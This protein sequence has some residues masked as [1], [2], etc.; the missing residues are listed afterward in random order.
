MS[1]Y[2]EDAVRGIQRQ[3]GL[4][5]PVEIIVVDDGSTDDTAQLA[6][7]LNCRV[8]PIPASGAPAARNTGIRAAQGNYLLL[9]DADDI[10]EEKALSVLYDALTA[11]DCQIVC[12]QVKEFVSPELAAASQTFKPK[13]A[14][15]F[16]V[17]AGCM[18]IRRT[19][20]DKV[21]LFDETLR[22]G[23]AIAWQ[24]T[25]HEKGI[26]VLKL[27]RLV[28]FRR[29]HLHNFSRVQKHQTFHD[30]ASILRKR[31]LSSPG[32]QGQT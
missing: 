11:S 18:L 5:V 24:L 2:L 20:F 32:K 3:Q 13:E 17:G 29:L 30:Y 27:P 8:I 15:Y 7:A 28:S 1:R 6:K 26:D 4:N 9:H 21:G 23:D 14:P 10:L 31:L 12:A 19:V 16:G 22:A 25:L